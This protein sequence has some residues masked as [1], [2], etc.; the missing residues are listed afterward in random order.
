VAFGFHLC[1]CFQL[2]VV[3]CSLSQRP[4]HRSRP[5]RLTIRPS[6]A[7]LTLEDV[8]R[9][10][11][12]LVVDRRGGQQQRAR[13]GVDAARA[14]RARADVPVQAFSPSIVRGKNRRDIGKSQSQWTACTMETPGVQH[15]AERVRPAAR[16]GP[17]TDHVRTVPATCSAAEPAALPQIRATIIRGRTVPRPRQ[18]R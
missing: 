16:P 6:T 9:Q 1:A 2:P 18:H 5:R 11:T 4:A 12:R 14:Q 3:H 7:P 15:G 13:A 10:Q 8:A 17:A